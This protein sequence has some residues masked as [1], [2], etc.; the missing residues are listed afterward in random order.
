MTYKTAQ[1]DPVRANEQ[2]PHHEFVAALEPD[3]TFA[4]A[5]RTLDPL[6]GNLPE[7]ITAQ[8]E[9]FDDLQALTDPPEAH[10]RTLSWHGFK[11]RQMLSNLQDIHLELLKNIEGLGHILKSHGGIS[12]D[13]L[14]WLE[15]ILDQQYELI[16]ADESACYR[17]IP[18]VAPLML[19]LA[20]A[21]QAYDKSPKIAELERRFCAFLIYPM[22]YRYNYALNL[23]YCY[24]RPV[25]PRQAVTT[26]YTVAIGYGL[27]E[28]K[29]FTESST[30][31]IYLKQD[32]TIST[33]FGAYNRSPI[34]T[35]RP[36]LVSH[37]QPAPY[38]KE[39]STV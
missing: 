18:F 2:K 12:G 19:D 29:L 31:A 34:G 11:H 7:K 38:V 1:H 25:S 13:D 21:A 16:E 5:H 10:W 37:I 14:E 4:H 20:R 9:I 39:A 26:P 22:E 3:Y 33:V 36:G 6:Q 28:C 15:D 30:P 17:E 27:G 35:D 8:A 24:S 23:T 32:L